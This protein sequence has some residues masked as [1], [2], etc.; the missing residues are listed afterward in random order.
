MFNWFKKEAPLKALAGLG[1]GVGRG[2]GSSEPLVIT[3]ASINPYSDSTHSWAF[4]V[5][6][7][8]ITFSRAFEADDEVEILLVGGGGGGGSNNWGATGGG[9]GGGVVFVPKTKGPEIVTSAGTHPI[10]VGTGGPIGNNGANTTISGN[11]IALTALG[12]GRGG[13]GGTGNP[14]GCGGG[15]QFQSGGGTGIQPSQNPGVSGIN[16]YGGNGN[17]G[18]GQPDLNGGGG[19]GAGGGGGPASVSGRAGINITP[20]SP[21]FITSAFPTPVINSMGLPENNPGYTYFG[22]G[23]AGGA[24]SNGPFSGGQGGG[25]NGARDPGGPDGTP[26]V[27]GRGGGGGG[28]AEASGQRP[29][30]PGGDGCFIIR[31]KLS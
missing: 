18:G 28:G 10:I 5:N 24:R 1:G 16:Q 11:A 31:W 27:N 26:G 17:S 7:D 21:G 12:G 14:G 19:G 8:P 25:G 20:L 22:A 6:S 15:G 13:N 30:A 2:G 23:G 9:G 3:G 4:Q 29:S